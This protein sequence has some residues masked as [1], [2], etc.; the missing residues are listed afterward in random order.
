MIAEDDENM[1]QLFV[2]NLA[3]AGY[4]P[5]LATD[6]LEAITLF[7]KHKIDLAVLDVMMPKMTGFQAARE[8]RQI[9]PYAA[10]LFVTARYS[11]ADKEN[12]FKLGCDDYIV[13]PFA[14]S[15]LLLRI[16]AILE[17][18]KGPTARNNEVLEFKTFRLKLRDRKLEVGDIVISLT[19][20]ES[21]ILFLLAA[22]INNTVTRAEILEKV[23][24]S[25]DIYNSKSLDVYLTRLRKYLKE[26]P[27]VELKNV[28]GQGFSLISNI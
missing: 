17:R 24:A 18:T 8:I 14:F 7:K 25:E 21:H 3:D 2:Q 13:K 23:W 15:E 12:G 1:G 28:Y 4:E 5:I 26:V 11:Q 16:N 6:G 10:F 20:K 19:G 27:E 22:N 9:D